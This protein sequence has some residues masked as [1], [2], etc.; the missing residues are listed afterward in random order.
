VL[1]DVGRPER[2]HVG[3]ESLTAQRGRL[4]GLRPSVGE[5]HRLEVLRG[6]VA[7]GGDYDGEAEAIGGITGERREVGQGV[8]GAR[9]A[10]HEDAGRRGRSVGARPVCEDLTTVDDADGIMAPSSSPQATQAMPSICAGVRFVE[11]K[12]A[13]MGLLLQG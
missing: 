6:V 9:V 13:S 10:D 7:T 4:E 1:V 8:S 5:H 2:A 3:E 12:R 11:S